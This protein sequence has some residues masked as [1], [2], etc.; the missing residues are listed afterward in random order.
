LKDEERAQKDHEPADNPAR[1]VHDQKDH[2]YADAE[3][4]GIG[5]PPA[6]Y[7]FKR[8][9]AYVGLHADGQRDAQDVVGQPAVDWIFPG[10]ASG[11]L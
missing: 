6:V 2:G 4:H 11:G 3:V 10:F 7:E 5:E 9:P 8:V 1:R